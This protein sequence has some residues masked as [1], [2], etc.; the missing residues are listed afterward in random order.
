[1]PD[2]Q[3]PAEGAQPAAAEAEASAPARVQD[4]VPGG[5][6]PAAT[7]TQA[8]GSARPAAA[9]PA[10]PAPDLPV[11]A[12]WRELHRV[13][14]ETA[15][16]FPGRL[17]V[18]AVD[19]TTGARYE[20]RAADRYHPASTFKLPV[21]LCVVEAIAAGDLAWDT[22]IEYA[23]RDHDDVGAGAFA[24]APFGTF[25][26]V[27]NLVYRSLVH[28]NNVAVRMLASTLTWEGLWV[29]TTAIGGPVTRTEE[30]S[31]PVSVRDEVAWWLY[32]WRMHQERPE[33][34]ETL[35]Q[36]LREVAYRGRIQAGTPRPDLVT[37]KFGSYDTNEHDG[38]IVWAD[39]PY[40]LVVLTHGAPEWQANRAIE[41]IAAAAWAAA[42]APVDPAPGCPDGA[43]A[44]L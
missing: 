26:P 39:R 19:L 1:M 2:G 31:T 34:A 15:A 16:G 41:T 24:T 11:P 5:E 12:R 36:P 4:G 25:Y 40:V 14:T 28:S 37:H 23:P 44:P 10:D 3:G 33:L 22:L 20:Y 13:V 7:G 29:C 6:P 43:D 32:L 35:L 8:D 42:H 27:E 30:G 18:G 17:S 9:E 38:A 21:T